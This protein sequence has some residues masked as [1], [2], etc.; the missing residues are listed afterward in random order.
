M[1]LCGHHLAT[2]PSSVSPVIVAA[3]SLP[4]SMEPNQRQFVFKP[5]NLAAFVV[6]HGVLMVAPKYLEKLKCNFQFS[7]ASFLSVISQ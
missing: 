5:C 1:P 3:I 2:F 7:T 6:S 4:L